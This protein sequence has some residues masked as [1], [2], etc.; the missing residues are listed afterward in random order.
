MADPEPPAGLKL[1]FGEEAIRKA[2]SSPVRMDFVETPLGDVVASLR[3]QYKIWICFDHG[4]LSDAGIGSDVQITRQLE[5]IPLR[6]ALDLL[7][8]DL[9]LTWVI[10][11]EVL[12]I[13]TLEEAHNR[14]ATKVYD[15]ADLVQFRDEKGDPWEDYVTLTEM[16]LSCIQPNTWDGVGGPGSIVGGT[17]GTA[18]VLVIS[19]TSRVHEEIDLLLQQ[20]RE[21]VRKTPGDGKPPLRPR[22]E[23]MQGSGLQGWPPPF[24]ATGPSK[25]DNPL[26]SEPTSPAQPSPPPKKPAE[27]RKVVR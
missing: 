25:P 23:P 5:G 11:D 24:P 20:I 6:S 16:I 26:K 18:K 17:F 15:V 7:L 9:G 3:Q 1:G 10:A 22:P 8:R 27:P 12:V 2:I 14:L 21:A 13:T 19:Q 4:A